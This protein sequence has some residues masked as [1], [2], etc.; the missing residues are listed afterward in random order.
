MDGG[1]MLIDS[2]NYQWTSP[3]ACVDIGLQV[4][5]PAGGTGI[6]LRMT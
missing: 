4:T 6:S 3:N 1:N 5:M 2:I